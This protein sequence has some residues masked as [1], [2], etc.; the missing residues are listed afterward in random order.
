MPDYMVTEEVAA[1]LRTSVDTVRYWRYSGRGP[2]AIKVGRRVLYDA[3]E[4]SR[5]IA[6]HDGGTAA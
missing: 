3:A 5:W 2:K 6:A 1:L 4:V